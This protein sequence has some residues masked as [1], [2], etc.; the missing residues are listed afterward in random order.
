MERLEHRERRGIK[1]PKGHRVLT[2]LK[3][4]KVIRGLRGHLVVE[5]RA[6]KD[7]KEPK[8]LLVLG[9]EHRENKALKVTKDLREQLAPRVHR[10]IKVR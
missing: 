10:V 4:P 7:T 2:E 1:A 3:E 5:L 6:L 8:D 9:K